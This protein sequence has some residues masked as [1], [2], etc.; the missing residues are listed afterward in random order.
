MFFVK[1]YA[2]FVF[3]RVENFIFICYNN[4]KTNLLCGKTEIGAE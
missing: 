3:K 4:M 1:I 2:F